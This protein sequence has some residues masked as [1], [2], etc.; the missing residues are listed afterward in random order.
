MLD[1]TARTQAW[2]ADFAAI[3]AEI[4]ANGLPLPQRTARKRA[5]KRKPLWEE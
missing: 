1:Q 4:E 5:R 2:L 3:N